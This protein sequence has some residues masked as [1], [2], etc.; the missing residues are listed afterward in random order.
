MAGGIADTLWGYMEA[1]IGLG[2]LFVRYKTCER[3]EARTLDR[4]LERDQLAKD[5]PGRTPPP[6]N[7]QVEAD[8]LTAFALLR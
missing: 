8:S 3:E 2:F 6:H 5:P 7:Q 4:R 1:F